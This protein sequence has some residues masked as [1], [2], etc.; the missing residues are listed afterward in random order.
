MRLIVA[1]LLKDVFCLSFVLRI[2][3]SVVF[4]LLIY[5]AAAEA[6]CFPVMFYNDFV[7]VFYLFMFISLVIHVNTVIFCEFFQFIFFLYFSSFS[8]CEAEKK[9]FHLRFVYFICM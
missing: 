8:D 6:I 3:F 7:V 9:V 5:I 4:L 1:N 2:F